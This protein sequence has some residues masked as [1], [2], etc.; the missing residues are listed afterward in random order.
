MVETGILSNNMKSS[1]SNAILGHIYWHPP[2][3]RH[4][5]KSWPYYRLW[6]YNRLW[7]Y[8]LIPRGFRRTFVL[9]VFSQQRKLIPPDTRPCPILDMYV[10]KCW[11][12]SLLNLSWV[13]ALTFEHHLVLVFCL[14]HTVQSR[15]IVFSCCFYIIVP[16]MF[17][18]HVQLS[19]RSYTKLN[20]F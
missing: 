3:I 1:L 20:T 11:Y 13:R 15:R 9:S 19:L 12:M 17:H 8:N 14:E 16:S 10:L 2:L 6:P 4:Y 7:L 18:F 5:T